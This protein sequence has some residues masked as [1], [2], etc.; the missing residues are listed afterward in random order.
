M[1]I[2]LNSKVRK[3][4]M[5]RKKAPKTPILLLFSAN[6]MRYDQR[7]LET[8]NCTDHT[9]ERDE[10]QANRI[11]VI[12]VIRGSKVPWLRPKAAMGK[13]AQSAD[14]LI[15]V[16]LTTGNCLSNRRGR[17]GPQ[18]KN[19]GRTACPVPLPFRAGSE[20]SRMG[21]QSTIK[22]PPAS[23]VQPRNSIFLFTIK[24]RRPIINGGLDGLQP[25]EEER[26]A[27]CEARWR[28][29]MARKRGGHLQFAHSCAMW[30]VV[31]LEGRC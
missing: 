24:D 4:R 1:S 27:L 5:S 6:I 29:W 15:P 21:P 30:Q 3:N 20:P 9:N 17:R 18:R 14:N 26:E 2:L 19:P 10:G 23:P 28:F 25:P 16:P 22:R 11:G 31:S 7:D 12:R 13:S 8:T